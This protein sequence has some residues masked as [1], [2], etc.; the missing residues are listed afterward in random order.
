MAKRKYVT[1]D[2]SVRFYGD[3][4]FVVIPIYGNLVFDDVNKILGCAKTQWY[5][6]GLDSQFD[7]N[8]QL[9]PFDTDE[10]AQHAMKYQKAKY[11]K[12][13]EERAER[14][15]QAGNKR[16]DNR[17]I[18]MQGLRDNLDEILRLWHAGDFVAL[19]YYRRYKCKRERDNLLILTTDDLDHPDIVPVAVW[20]CRKCRGGRP[21]I[22]F[23][24]DSYYLY[25]WHGEN[26]LG[27][28]NL[29]VRTDFWIEIDVDSVPEYAR[30]KK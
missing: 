21:L 16:R 25:S 20:E 27:A 4:F 24:E 7:A 9:G 28:N 2:V 11:G 19:C 22:I 13:R 8:T 18:R 10:E 6:I 17:E 29:R 14:L 12:W 15:L 30:S 23:Y 26:R 3:E 5:V 1:K